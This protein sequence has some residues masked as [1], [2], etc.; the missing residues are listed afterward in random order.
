MSR[1]GVE[2]VVLFC[3]SPPGWLTRNGHTFCTDDCSPS[4]LLP[5]AEPAFAEYVAEIATHI[6]FS[7]E[8]RAARPGAGQNEQKQCRR[9]SI[10]VVGVAPINEP[11]WAWIGGEQEGCR[12]SN[13]AFI[14]VARALR[15]AL[16][17][18]GLHG[19]AVLG[20]DSGCLDDMWALNAAATERYGEPFGAYCSAL[21]SDEEETALFRE[22]ILTTHSYWS[23]DPDRELA[24]RRRRL[25]RAV[26]QG[27]RLWQ[28]E[29]CQMRSG[30]SARCVRS[31]VLLARLIH[32]D[33]AVAGASSWSW[34]L[35]VS[36][37]DY[38]DG[39]VYV[40]GPRTPWEQRREEEGGTTSGGG[41]G[42]CD[43]D[44]GAAVPT[45]RLFA[46]A[47]FSRFVRPGYVRVGLRMWASSAAAT[48][49]A[50]AADAAAADDAAAAAAA[51]DTHGLLASAYVSPDGRTLVAVLVNAAG[52]D[53]A[54]GE[55]EGE[56]AVPPVAARAV[57]ELRF[58]QQGRALLSAGSNQ[59]GGSPLGSLRLWLT[60]ET[61]DC[62]ELCHGVVVC[63]TAAAVVV[64]FAVPTCSVITAVLTF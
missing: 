30:A 48:A 1:Y 20:P 16:D 43:G 9:L 62:E 14:R 5:G 40:P 4:N 54:E 38:A 56:G 7:E 34:W 27:W 13:A 58:S 23:D 63:A 37:Y 25:A 19:A 42:P 10:P 11:Q 47:H 44:K 15:S 49:D 32:F 8:E 64:N 31:A 29:Y 41:G 55:C 21:A 52:C 59:D 3:N 28:T 26:P 12:C 2:A 6:A 36:C 61:H 39:L 51:D 46:L 35:G 18:R 24:Q 60:D 53:D 17:A 57:V 45:K 50:A 22:R 33:L